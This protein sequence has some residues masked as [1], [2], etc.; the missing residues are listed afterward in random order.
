[1]TEDL[2]VLLDPMVDLAPIEGE[3]VLDRRDF[4]ERLLVAPDGVFD[5]AVADLYG[6]I[7]R[8]ALV[9]TVRAVVGPLQEIHAHVPPRE[10]TDWAIAGLKQK[11]RLECVGDRRV[12][13]DDAHPL[14]TLLKGEAMI[15]LAHRFRKFHDLFLPIRHA[16]LPE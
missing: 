1:M 7:R 6:P 5:P 8:I 9:G 12:G 11:A 13:D 16:R 2:L 4:R 10:I 15:G 3:V 14:R